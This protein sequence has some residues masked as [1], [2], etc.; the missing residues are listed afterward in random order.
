MV[1]AVRFRGVF[2][3]WLD[4]LMRW[5]GAC[6]H[7]C[8]EGVACFFR[9]R[10]LKKAYDTGMRILKEGL[11]AAN[12]WS[13]LKFGGMVDV[14]QEAIACARGTYAAGVDFL[15][16]LNQLPWILV[17]LDTPGIKAQVLRLWALKPKERH[18]P[19]TREFLD[20]EHDSGLR[21]MVDNMN[22]DGSGVD[23]PLQEAICALENIP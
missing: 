22:E 11:D 16:Y 23:G 5:V 6:R 7:N 17:R 10:L 18:H 9:G 12:D 4:E 19:L 15:S 21:A 13:M 20:P 2:C 8:A 3:E 1:R 14:W